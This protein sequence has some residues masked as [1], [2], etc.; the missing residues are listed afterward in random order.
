MRRAVGKEAFGKCEHVKS[1]LKRRSP[2]WGLGKRSPAGG[3]RTSKES[4][5]DVCSITEMGRTW[6][7]LA[8]SELKPSAQVAKL[9]LKAGAALT[10]R[11][12]F[13]M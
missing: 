2:G 12:K 5:C 8:S 6:G 9:T 4:G 7:V 10:L 1:G 13:F 3:R 11:N